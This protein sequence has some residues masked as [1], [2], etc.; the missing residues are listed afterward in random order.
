[1]LRDVNIILARIG[2]ELRQGKTLM[3][4]TSI[5]A[6]GETL[7]MVAPLIVAKVFSP[8]L[9]ASYSL[10][11]MVVFFFSAS[12]ISSSQ[13][14]FIIFANQ[15]KLAGGRINRTFSV[16]LTFLI[17]SLFLFAAMSLFLGGYIMA[18][19]GIN[20]GDLPFVLL[21]FSG[22]AVKTTLC[23]LFM[24]LD[25]RVTNS[26]AELAFGSVGLALIVVLCLLDRI[27]LRMVLLIHFASSVFVVVLFIRAVDFKLLL[28]FDLDAQHLRRIFDFTKWVFVGVTAVY[29]I[30][31]GDN[32]VLRY[33]VSMEDIGVYNLGYQLFKGLVILIAILGSYFLPFLS[34]NINDRVK[35]RQYLYNKRPRILVLAF[36]GIVLV[37]VA[38]PYIFRLYSEVY[39]ESVLVLRVLLIAAVT[40]SYSIFYD[41]ILN[42]LKVYKFAQTVNLFQVLL[43]LLL[44][45]LLVPAMGILGAAIA[46]TLAYLC[47]AVTIEIYFRVKLK[48][49]LG[50]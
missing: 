2:R 40:I 17:L 33:F 39:S 8:G 20:R 13:V 21:A 15:E 22:L 34:Q 50:L 4:F 25:Q 6:L 12:L 27:N 48:K 11:R 26:L 14:P 45:V 19:T 47:R 35:V 43:N 36:I 44:D 46:T 23:N 24:A 29:F 5:R 38:A 37:F 30:D 49:M 41:P 16:Q 31:W 7:G 10:A 9:F 28:P 3:T 42:V 32:L 18:F 1:M